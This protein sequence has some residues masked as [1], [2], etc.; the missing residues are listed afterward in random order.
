MPSRCQVEVPDGETYGNPQSSGYD[1]A[2]YASEMPGR[3]TCVKLIAI[4]LLE[5]ASEMP[6]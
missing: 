1:I 3:G 4:I 5:Y 6:G 2:E